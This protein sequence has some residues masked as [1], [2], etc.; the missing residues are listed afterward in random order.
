MLDAAVGQ[1]AH[2][3]KRSPVRI[4]NVGQVKDAIEIAPL[5]DNRLGTAE[6]DGYHAAQP[7]DE[8]RHERDADHD[9]V[10]RPHAPRAG[11]HPAYEPQQAGCR[12][13][14]GI[15]AKFGEDARGDK[16]YEYAAQNSAGGNRQ[17]EGREV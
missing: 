16:G 11:P 8:Q 10:F 4:G 2:P 9:V 1:L 15:F 17:V 13:P 6:I 5:G 7:A 3:T 12:E 14:D